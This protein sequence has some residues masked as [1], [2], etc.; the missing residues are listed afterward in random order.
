MYHFKY[1]YFFSPTT[2]SYLYDFALSTN[3]KYYIADGCSFNNFA[4]RGTF[5]LASN[6]DCADNCFNDPDGCTY[7][8]MHTYVPFSMGSSV[9]AFECLL[10]NTKN[11]GNATVIPTFPYSYESFGTTEYNITKFSCGF[12]TTSVPSKPSF[13][14]YTA[15]CGAITIRGVQ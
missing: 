7:F 11:S 14:S 9:Y 8:E 5:K 6:D 4:Y 1:F 2:V 12:P 15:V 10:F 3:G 13:P